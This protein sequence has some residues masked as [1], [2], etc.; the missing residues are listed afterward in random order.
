M[1]IANMELAIDFRD[2]SRLVV[3]NSNGKCRRSIEN[4]PT[5]TPEAGKVNLK[6]LVTKLSQIKWGCEDGQA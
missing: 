6:Y 4:M 5:G 3:S 1:R 2:G